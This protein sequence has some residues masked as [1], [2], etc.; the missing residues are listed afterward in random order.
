MYG[1]YISAFTAFNSYAAANGA[2][3]T[4]RVRAMRI[5][6][7]M[8]WPSKREAYEYMREIEGYYSK[9]LE[10]RKIR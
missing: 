4:K 8:A 1:I 2:P 6:D 5:Y 10:V 7:D 3:H 9:P